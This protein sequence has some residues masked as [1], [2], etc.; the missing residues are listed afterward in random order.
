MAAASENDEGSCCIP[1]GFGKIK[2]RPFGD[3]AKTVY[4]LASADR[5]IDFAASHG[6]RFVDQVL[7]LRV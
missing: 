1:A 4:A 7:S 3:P 2:F 5:R 6:L